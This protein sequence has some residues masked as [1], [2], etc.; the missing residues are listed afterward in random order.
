MRPKTS[1]ECVDTRAKL[2]DA[3]AIMSNAFEVETI[4]ELELGS[5]VFH[6]NCVKDVPTF[7]TLTLEMR[8][9]AK[10][11]CGSSGF[12]CAGVA[13][14]AGVGGGGGGG[15]GPGGARGGG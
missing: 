15:G 1:R 8:G 6:T 14:G 11:S 12:C 3:V 10:S 7:C 9:A 4:T 5:S 2:D 13:G